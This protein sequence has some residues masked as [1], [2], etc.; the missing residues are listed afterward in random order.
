[1]TLR[2]LIIAAVLVGAGVAAY[3]SLTVSSRRIA[4]AERA[5]ATVE[6]LKSAG[7]VRRREFSTKFDWS[8]LERNRATM[9]AAA[10]ELVEQSNELAAESQSEIEKVDAVIEHSVD[11]ADR[12]NWTAIRAALVKQAEAAAAYA[13][14]YGAATSVSIS[15]RQPLAERAG[16][17]IDRADTLG[18]AADRL[19]AEAKSLRAQTP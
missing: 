14:G 13:E 8:Q 6:E 10:G 5:V 7:V 11:A 4:A 16:P 19:Y 2:N 3:L 15:E 1:M 12:R 9:I 17:L 18:T